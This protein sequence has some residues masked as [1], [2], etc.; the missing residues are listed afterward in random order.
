MELLRWLDG[1]PMFEAWLGVAVVLWLIGG[2][3]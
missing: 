2:R 3:R 1:H